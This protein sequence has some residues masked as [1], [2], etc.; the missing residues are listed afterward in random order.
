MVRLSATDI[1]SSRTHADPS[2]LRLA[3]EPAGCCQKVTE[4]HTVL[5]ASVQWG[6]RLSTETWGKELYCF[7]S[8]G[9]PVRSS[10]H[11]SVFLSLC[12]SITFLGFGCLSNINISTKHL[13]VRLDL[14]W[15]DL[16]YINCNVRNLTD[17]MNATA[18]IYN[19]LETILQRENE[20]SAKKKDNR[21][22]TN[23][24]QSNSTT[25][26]FCSIVSAS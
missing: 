8:L 23:I 17:G 14:S 11:L 2:S 21:T 25:Q 19:Q 18:A 22:I 16:N 9:L 4:R 15:P 13:T 12:L 20:A 6:D 1:P 3:D 24:T 7:L 26:R 10:V 5:L